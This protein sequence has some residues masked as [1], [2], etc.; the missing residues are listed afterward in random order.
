MLYALSL[1]GVTCQ[2][3]LNTPRKKNHSGMC[4]KRTNLDSNFRISLKNFLKK[5]L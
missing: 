5:K 1:Y 3:Y 2:L 4:V